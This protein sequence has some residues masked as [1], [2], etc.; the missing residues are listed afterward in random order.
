MLK[1]A[2]FSKSVVHSYS[3]TDKLNVKSLND[4]CIVYLLNLPSLCKGA[5]SMSLSLKNVNLKSS[6]SSS[7]ITS[8]IL[9]KHS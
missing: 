9:P 8:T 1:L 5:Y 7:V 3:L 4:V 2:R 6:K